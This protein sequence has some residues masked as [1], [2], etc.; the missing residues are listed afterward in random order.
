M[1]TK[2][3]LSAEYNSSIGALLLA[4]LFSFLDMFCMLV[5]GSTVIPF[6]ALP[7]SLF[8]CFSSFLAD[9]GARLCA[10]P[11][12]LIS[13]GFLVFCYI[14]SAKPDPN[15]LKAFIFAY[16]AD[17]LLLLFLFSAIEKGTFVF[18]LIF[19]AGMLLLLIR[20]LLFAKKLQNGDF[21]EDEEEEKTEQQNRTADSDIIRDL[22]KGS[23]AVYKFDRDYAAENKANKVG[24]FFL[25][26]LCYLVLGVAAVCFAMEITDIFDAE[27][28]ITLLAMALPFTL[29]T[30]LFIILAVQ[31][32]PFLTAGNA[33]Y[34]VNK[35][36]LF[37][38][39]M[40]NELPHLRYIEF[41][42]ARLTKE[43]HNCWVIEYRSLRGRRKK[44]VIPKAYPKLKDYIET[45]KQDI[46]STL[47]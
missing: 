47:R 8:G 1:K 35:D 43:K 44:C 7:Y 39:V 26:L 28:E 13:I 24:M 9:W 36:G 15:W 42:N 33:T 45:L 17:T 37:L 31:L 14:K 23:S 5:R 2:K 18:G 32:A 30:A 3:T 19:H 21:A 41:H 4:A 46:Q 10:V 22:S 34:L 11:F 20:A 40:P 29:L 12:Y 38:R 25:S 16:S 27:I 6:T